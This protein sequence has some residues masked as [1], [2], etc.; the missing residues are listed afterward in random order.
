VAYQPMGPDIPRELA[1]FAQAAG[2][3]TGTEGA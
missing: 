1:T 2:L 3:E